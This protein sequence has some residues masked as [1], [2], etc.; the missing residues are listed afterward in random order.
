LAVGHIDGKG[1]FLRIAVERTVFAR[2]RTASQSSSVCGPH[3][4][5]FLHVA[6]R[7]LSIVFG[8]RLGTLL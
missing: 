3:A 1:R 5:H 7:F 4:G 2:P 6:V 8:R